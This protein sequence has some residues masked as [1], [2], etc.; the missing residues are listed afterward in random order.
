VAVQLKSYNIDADYFHA[1]LTAEEKNTK[2]EQWIG[3]KI[4]TIVCTRAFGMG[5]DKPDVRTVI[6]FDAPDSLESYYQEAGRAGRDNK[7]AYA[8]LLYQQKDLTYLNEQVK[9]RFPDIDEVKRVYQAIVNYL[10]IPEGNGESNYYD[11]ILS[12]FIEKFKLTSHVVINSL[13]VLEQENLVSFNEQIFLPSRVG[14]VCN[15][16]TL[17]DFESSHSDLEPL[18]K[19]LLRSYEGIF[20]QEVNVNE[21]SLAY[22]TREDVTQVTES[23]QILSRYH[24]ITY[25]PQK[26]LPQLYFVT[27]RVKVQDL[28]INVA[29]YHQLKQQYAA[30]LEAM[31]KYIGT[32]ECRSQFIGNYFGDDVIRKCGV[33]DNCL[34]HKRTTLSKDEFLTIEN[35]IMTALKK[36]P[37]DSRDIINLI[38]GIKKEKAWKVIEFLQAEKK[39]EVSKDG[40]LRVKE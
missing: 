23:L 28:V 9:L 29:A 12:D 13:K 20:D 31:Q 1:G 38:A 10:Q 22:L 27:N 17:Y 4:R 39:I 2:Q 15:K 25:V 14:F 24:I 26:D 3:N 32:S 21:K 34:Q 18:I 5:I 40:V 33:C 36:H 7:K 35:Q 37:V 30:R 8:V 16:D 11:F 19:A 6:H